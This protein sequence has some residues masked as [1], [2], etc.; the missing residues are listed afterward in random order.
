MRGPEQ[1]AAEVAARHDK[2]LKA[3]FQLFSQRNIDYVTIEAVAKQAGLT[4]RTLLRHFC[5]KPALVVE[6]ATWAW[7]N[8][9]EENRKNRKNP[10]ELSAA[11]DYKFFLDSFLALYRDH[12]DLLRFNQFFNVYVSSEQISG[13]GLSP[14]QGLMNT[15][16]ERFRAVYAKGKEDGTLRAEI[17]EENMFSA[18]LHLMLAA[19]TR[20]AVGL[21]YK[22]GVS[23]EEELILL[24]D[25]LLEKYTAQ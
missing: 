10:G 8:F 6:T 13:D 7:Q 17:A 4:S 11:E 25:M 24:R 18:T 12:R 22:G 9:L 19:V 14:Y 20:Y 23:P 5:G 16:R 2:L 21:V 3:A 1:Y 15:L